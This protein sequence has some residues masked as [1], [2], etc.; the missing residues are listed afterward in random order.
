MGMYTQVRGIL[1][2]G[3]I[4]QSL[5]NNIPK[6]LKELQEQ[7]LRDCSKMYSPWIGECTYYQ[8]SGNNSEW[9]TILAEFKNYDESM[10]KWIEYLIENIMCEGRIEFQYEENDVNDRDTVLIIKNSKITKME[11]VISTQG[12]GFE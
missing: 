9:L 1:C 3:S 4:G 10:M 6:K 11:Y 7:F 8:R 2:C 12:Y 5:E